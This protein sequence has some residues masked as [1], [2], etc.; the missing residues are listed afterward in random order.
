MVADGADKIRE[1][2]GTFTDKVV[3]KY[4]ARLGQA[5]PVQITAQ[6]FLRRIQNDSWYCYY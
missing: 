2:M 4:A 6:P 5:F 3:A 1:W